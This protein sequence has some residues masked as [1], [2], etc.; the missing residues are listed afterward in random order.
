MLN[1]SEILMKHHNIETFEKLL[2]VVQESARTS[3]ELFFRLDVKPPY[4]DTPPNWEEQLESAF[5]SVNTN[6]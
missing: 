4:A 1:L 6:R 5:S 3:G 2:N